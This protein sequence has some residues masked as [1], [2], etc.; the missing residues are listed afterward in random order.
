MKDFYGSPLT[1]SGKPYDDM[2][3]A[4]FE[5]VY[6][7][8]GDQ[9]SS[10]FAFNI[11]QGL[12]VMPGWLFFN[13]VNARAR[14]GVEIGPTRL[15]LRCIVCF[16][17]KEMWIQCQLW[18]LWQMSVSFLNQLELFILKFSSAHSK[19]AWDMAAE[20]CLS[21]LP[22]LVEDRNAEFQV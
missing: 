14:K 20:I 9:G 8:S 19:D 16:K 13:R 22:S 1:A 21:H 17:G 5:C 18:V 7:G 3:V 12:P 15:L 4:E 10:M 6:N 11:E 2:L